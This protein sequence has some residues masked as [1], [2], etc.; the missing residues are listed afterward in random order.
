LWSVAASIC[1]VTRR[2]ELVNSRRLKTGLPLHPPPV[3]RI[4][5][6]PG[7]NNRGSTLL[8][9]GVDLRRAHA[10]IS[11]R[12]TQN[13][14]AERPWQEMQRL[15]KSFRCKR[16]VSPARCK[17]LRTLPSNPQ[18]RTPPRKST[19]AMVMALRSGGTQHLSVRKS[20]SF[21]LNSRRFG[22]IS[23]RA[24]FLPCRHREQFSVPG[25]GTY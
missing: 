1:R 13:C 12:P 15:F 25:R 8:R 22:G 4:T 19:F 18:A 17:P 2:I 7:Y 5:W 20:V 23:M 11:R 14:A 6:R 3:A 9:S 21:L 24:C 16:L 10:S